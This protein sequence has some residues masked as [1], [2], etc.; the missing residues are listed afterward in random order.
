MAEFDKDGNLIPGTTRNPIDW[1]GEVADTSGNIPEIEIVADRPEATRS[2]SGPLAD[3]EKT[4][5]GQISQMQYPLD[6]GS[7]SKPHSVIFYISE[8]KSLDFARVKELGTSLMALEETAASAMESAKAAGNEAIAANDAGGLKAVAELEFN[9]LKSLFESTVGSIKSISANN[10]DF[11]GKFRPT[12]EGVTAA[13]RLYMP[14]TLQIGYQAMYDKLSLAQAASSVP[15]VGGIARAITGAESNAAARLAL[16]KLGYT[17]NPQAQ[18]TFNGIDFREYDMAFTFTP[19]SR[20]ESEMVSQ[21]I[22]A[23]R[24][25]AAPTVVD[26]AFGFFFKPPALFDVAFMA[27][28][29]ENPHIGKIRRSVLTNIVVDYAP[30]QNWAALKNGAPVQ[31]TITMSFRETELVDRNS[32][33]DEYK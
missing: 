16:N 30:N 10:K 1:S 14:D 5:K 15:L 26:E 8:V 24:M 28:D 7:L 4:E 32:I 3:L 9:K 12:T 29:S 18:A 25:Y 19:S 21:I 22:K 27:G 20:K 11:A 2:L 17:F 31:T 33:A 13:I 6:L 23:F